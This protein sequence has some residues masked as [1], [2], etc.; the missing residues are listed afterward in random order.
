MPTD[1]YGDAQPGGVWSQRGHLDNVDHL[2]VVAPL[3]RLRNFALPKTPSNSTVLSAH[4][5]LCS[6]KL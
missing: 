5:I 2:S 6:K 4:D 1:I 3:S